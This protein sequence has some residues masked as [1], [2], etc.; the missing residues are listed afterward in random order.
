MG[1]PR[2]RQTRVLIHWTAE[3]GR[4]HANA[5]IQRVDKESSW[6]LMHTRARLIQAAV[7]LRSGFLHLYRYGAYT[8]ESLCRISIL[9]LSIAVAAINNTARGY[10][11]N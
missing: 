6:L 9:P 7:T 1:V 4:Y 8:L 11:S 10:R 2:G 5:T 3:A